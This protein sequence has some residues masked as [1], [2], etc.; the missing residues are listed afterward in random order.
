[1]TD[2]ESINATNKNAVILAAITLSVGISHFLFTIWMNFII[3]SDISLNETLSMLIIVILGTLTKLTGG[4]YGSAL[5]MI[6]GIVIIIKWRDQLLA[7]KLAVF[8]IIISFI[9]LNLMFLNMLSTS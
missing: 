2:S 6:L 1:M 9:S 8:G 4:I 3:Q 7:K 5:V